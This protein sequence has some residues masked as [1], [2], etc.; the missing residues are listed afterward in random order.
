MFGP[1]SRYSN[2]ALRRYLR[3][4]HDQAP[5]ATDADGVEEITYVGRRFIPPSGSVP[6][7]G[8][9]TVRAADRPD[10]LS[11]AAYADPLHYWRIADANEVRAVDE[12]T[13]EI[14]RRLD[15][16]QVMPP[17]SGE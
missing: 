4:T 2:I 5:S 6:S 16:G 7:I 12:L 15:V 3:R 14:G 17:G 8:S 9:I 13:E 1:T 11:A 10:H